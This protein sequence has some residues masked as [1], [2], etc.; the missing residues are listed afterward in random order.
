MCGRR[1]GPEYEVVVPWADDLARDDR[2]PPLVE[3]RPPSPTP[4]LT[5]TLP[6]TIADPEVQTPT[7]WGRGSI[8]RNHGEK[9]NH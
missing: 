2:P 1:H 3:V 8:Q 5:P 7:P 9:N 4:G 6:E